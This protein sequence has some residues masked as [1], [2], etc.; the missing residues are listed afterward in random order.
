M[1]VGATGTTLLALPYGKWLVTAPGGGQTPI[2]LT[3][4][5]PTG[6]VSLTDSSH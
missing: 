6:T 3:S 2:S 5:T 4:A 1:S